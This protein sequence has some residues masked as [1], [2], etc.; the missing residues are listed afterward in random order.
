MLCPLVAMLAAC[1]QQP[2]IDQM[3]GQ[4][5]V[6]RTDDGRLVAGQLV[7]ADADTVVL[8]R[9]DGGD[10]SLDRHAVSAVAK[11]ATPHDGSGL[12]HA[13]LDARRVSYR[14]VTVPAGTTLR[15][16]LDNALGSD[17]SHVEDQV[18]A[19]LA[20]PVSR[21][22]ADVV[23]AGSRLTGTV[24]AAQPS[25]KVTGRARLAFRFDELAIGGHGERLEIDTR[26][27]VVE[28]A[29]TKQKDAE[30]I[31]IGAA[32]GAIIGGLVG[33]GSGA[34]KGALIG[35][36][37]GTA[38]VLT[39]RGDEVHLAQGT[40]VDVRLAQPLTFQVPAGPAAR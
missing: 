14:E 25:A 22:G 37:A 32:A 16:K 8:K 30:K 28:A 12:S 4:Q 15:V 2:Q 29:G 9:A 1:G 33:G 23:P 24:T 6:V 38:A 11:P 3:E 26:P 27:V 19:S 18:R 39:T 20:Q 36:G 13:E 21:D 17:V 5:V 40:V 31:G 10:T 34:A 7:K 35:G